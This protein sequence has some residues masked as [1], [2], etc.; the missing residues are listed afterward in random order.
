[1]NGPP[2]RRRQ[3]GAGIAEYALGVSFL[4]AA[5]VMGIGSVND[6]ASDELADRGGS[7]GH[8]TEAPS[9]SGGP[10]SGPEVP[11]EGLPGGGTETPPYVGSIEGNCNG[12][13]GAQDNCSFTLNPNPPAGMTVVWAVNPNMG[14]TGTAPN[15]TFTDKQTRTIQATVGDS[16]TLSRTVTCKTQA[17][18]LRCTIS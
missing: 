17:S 5:L 14:Y 13:D 16:T 18:K 10:G 4:G 3:R 2:G 9:A 8:P 7:I 11:E 1:M 12:N 6:A 15:V